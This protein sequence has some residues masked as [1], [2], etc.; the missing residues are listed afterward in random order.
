MPEMKT[1]FLMTR[2]MRENC[3]SRADLDR[4]AGFSRVIDE[5]HDQLDEDKM[6]HLADDVDAIL[7]CWGTPSL[8]PKV[9]EASARLGI[10]CHAAGTVKPYIDEKS[11]PII[12]GKNIA[13]TN[14][15]AALGVGVAEFTLGMIIT[16]LKKVF[17][18]RET[19]R[20]GGWHEVRGIV[21][22]PYDV[23]IGII[24]AGSCGRHV[25][26][27]LGNFELK[28]LVYDPYKSAEECR[29]LGADK[30]E[31]DQLMSVSDVISLHA[32][33][34]PQNAKMI[35]R[36]LIKKIKD[37]AVFINTARGMEVDEAAL[38]DEL[39]TGRFYACLD[40]TDPE[41]PA[42]DNPLRRLKNVFL[43]P[44]IAG[45]ASNGMKRQGR[46]AVDELQRF[47]NG[48]PVLYAI[49]KDRMDI[50]A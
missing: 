42:A 16:S 50:I 14:T 49:K 32:P 36:A 13:V 48:E 15:A 11:W 22:D 1:A 23:T 34:I 20:N 27:L 33:N 29:E 12:W 19:M 24:G 41:P 37:G 4:L 39:K 6:V 25:I 21:S 44:H 7:S 30:V 35:S 31:L 45:H 9:L 47:A 10:I 40:V 17:F 5:V 28:V 43:T 18:M 3:F 26:K 46:Y 8:T 38:I 2:D